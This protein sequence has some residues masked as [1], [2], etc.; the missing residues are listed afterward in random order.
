MI[1][2]AE[3]VYQYLI[4]DEN[5]A[6][7]QASL[8]PMIWD[9][10]IECSGFSVSHFQQKIG[11]DNFLCSLEDCQSFAGRMKT[12]L[13]LNHLPHGVLGPAKQHCISKGGSSER[14][15]CSV[16]GSQRAAWNHAGHPDPV[17][18]A[19]FVDLLK[20][21]AIQAF[22]NPLGWRQGGVVDTS[23]NRDP[24]ELGR[25]GEAN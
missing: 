5:I 2:N 24:W 23:E 1:S 13:G 8:V 3:L 14:R 7:F 22:W 11:T 16:P 9:Q 15:P 17:L 20:P 19:V 18:D 25:R 6:A 4:S 10:P 21:H 12:I